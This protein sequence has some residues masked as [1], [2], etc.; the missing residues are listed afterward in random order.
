MWKAELGSGIPDMVQNYAKNRGLPHGKP[1][2]MLSGRFETHGG[3]TPAN[4]LHLPFKN[5][6]TL[7]RNVSRATSVVAI[8]VLKTFSLETKA[9]QCNVSTRPIRPK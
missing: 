3:K 6:E 8:P 1:L 4:V 5:A 2:G 9:L 7:H